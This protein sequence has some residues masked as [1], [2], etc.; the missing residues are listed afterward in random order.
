MS[1]QHKAI[2]INTTI[3]A[4]FPQSHVVDGT[5]Q[6]II[7]DTQEEAQAAAD[8]FAKEMEASTGVT[9][10]NGFIEGHFPDA[11]EPEPINPVVDTGPGTP[12]YEIG[13]L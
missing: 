7:Y 12:G 9:G 4:F 2:A 1:K 11:V 3:N 5:R 10:W 6:L 8:E 13:T